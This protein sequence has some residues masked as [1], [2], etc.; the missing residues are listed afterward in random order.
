MPTPALELSSP[1]ERLL[2]RDRF[3]LALGLAAIT[4]LAWM[5]LVRMAGDMR[6]MPMDAEMAAM[7]MADPHVWG[8]A[9]WVMLFVM[10]SVMMVA[11]MLPS[12]APVI[13]LVLGVY[14]RRGDSRARLS[15]ISFVTGYVLVWTSFSA[16]AAAAQVL[17]HRAAV[18]NDEMSARSAVAAGIILVCA[19]IYQFLPIKASCLKH[20]QSPLAFLGTHWREG[21]RGA[22]NMGLHHGMFCVGCCWALMA[23]LFA[24][25][26]MNLLWVAAVAAFVLVEKLAPPRFSVGRAA[27]TLLIVWGVFQFVRA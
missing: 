16:V 15:A 17:L 19:G 26:V 24:L 22:L 14:R 13:L 3:I 1:L 12:A 11:M 23:V 27:G 21:P 9:D 10:W 6:S 25:G 4:L 5:Y 18:L 7:G 8:P 20:C 2:R